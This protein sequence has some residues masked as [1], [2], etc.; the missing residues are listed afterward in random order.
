MEKRQGRM[1]RTKGEGGG[2]G[3]GYERVRG[4]RSGRVSWRQTGLEPLP[5][6]T[7]Y[8]HVSFTILLL[9]HTCSAFTHPLRL[10]SLTRPAHRLLHPCP[11]FPP[12]YRTYTFQTLSTTPTYIIQSSPTYRIAVQTLSI[13]TYHHLHTFHTHL[14]LFR[15]SSC[16]V[17]IIKHFPFPASSVPV[18]FLSLPPKCLRRRKLYDYR[19]FL[20]IMLGN[21]DN[22]SMRA[23][24]FSFFL[25]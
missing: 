2:G 15:R 12:T 7:H 16:Q 14:S 11:S 1:S 22:V 21:S 20:H 19:R 9:T 10:P 25:L 6:F 17:I 4:Q 13:P 3:C 18:E 8:P 5:H 24:I 23:G